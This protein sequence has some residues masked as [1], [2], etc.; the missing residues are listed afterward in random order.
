[1]SRGAAPITLRD[2]F[3]SP[4][5]RERKNREHA[6]YRRHRFS[7]SW[8]TKAASERFITQTKY[9]LIP[10]MLDAWQTVSERARSREMHTGEFELS[11][12]INI[13]TPL[14]DGQWKL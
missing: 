1:M 14:T 10:A 2:I 9:S 4:T 6:G 11:I 8:E 7:P 12:L 3:L 5:E 13:Q